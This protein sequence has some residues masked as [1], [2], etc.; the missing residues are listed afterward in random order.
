MTSFPVQEQV[1]SP[2]P[3]SSLS[4][5][6][7]HWW[8]QIYQGKEEK[9]TTCYG[10]PSWVSG[11]NMPVKA[12]MAC[13]PIQRDREAPWHVVGRAHLATAHIQDVDIAR[14][15]RASSHELKTS[16]L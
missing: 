16:A 14:R 11:E 10:K 7:E 8:R 1:Q 4:K 3:A 5:V 13:F 9:I 6:Q 12:D 15:R 2:A